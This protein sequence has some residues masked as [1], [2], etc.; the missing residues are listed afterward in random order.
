MENNILDAGAAKGDSN[1]RRSSSFMIASSLSQVRSSCSSSAAPSNSGVGGR[2][3]VSLESENSNVELKGGVPG[4]E[5]GSDE[6][7]KLGP[8]GGVL[9]SKICSWGGKGGVVAS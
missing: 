7:A 3:Q 5:L 1:S 8:R 4:G 2:V 9:A 6:G